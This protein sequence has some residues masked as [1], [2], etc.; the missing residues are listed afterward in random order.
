MSTRYL[1][2]RLNGSVGP[3]TPTKVHLAE[4]GLFFSLPTNDNSRYDRLEILSCSDESGSDPQVIHT[5]IDPEKYLSFNFIPID[6]VRNYL[7]SEIGDYE[8]DD[9]STDNFSDLYWRLLSSRWMRVDP[10]KS[11]LAYWTNK[12]EIPKA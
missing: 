2:A 8:L 3:T 7:P 10:S 9:E 6:Q 4:S 5:V 11:H 12:L 1:R